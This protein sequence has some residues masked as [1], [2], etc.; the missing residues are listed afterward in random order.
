MVMLTL[1]EKNINPFKIFN[2]NRH[3]IIRG[4]GDLIE[5]KNTQKV[6]LCL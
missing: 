6:E 3:L 1:I 5:L 4:E 2:Q